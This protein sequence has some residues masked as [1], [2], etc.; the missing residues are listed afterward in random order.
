MSKTVYGIATDL[1]YQESIDIAGEE[2]GSN[3][4]TGET[5]DNGKEFIDSESDDHET[6]ATSDDID[7]VNDTKID[8]L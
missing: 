5:I 1:E 4:T 3:T 2:M 6:A 7:L 8:T